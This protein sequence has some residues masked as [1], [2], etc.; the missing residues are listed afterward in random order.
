LTSD[1]ILCYY[2]HVQIKYITLSKA[3]ELIGCTREYMRVMVRAGKFPSAHQISEEP[4]APFIVSEQEVLNY[5][6]SRTKP[7]NKKAE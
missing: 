1:S 6:K 3:A 4:N 5:Q 2:W 7:F